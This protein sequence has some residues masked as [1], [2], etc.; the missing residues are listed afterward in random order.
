MAHNA[1]RIKISSNIKE[2][3]TLL[4]MKI[5]NLNLVIAYRPHDHIS[6]LHK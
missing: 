5:R 2:Y 3:R 6:A 1:K 4:G